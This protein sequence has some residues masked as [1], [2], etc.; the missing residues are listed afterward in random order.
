MVALLPI[1]IKNCNIPQKW[2]VV[3]GQT[4]REVLNDVHWRVFQPPT[5]KQ[6]PTTERG[7]YNVLCADG[8]FRRCK[9]VLAAWL[10]D[11]LGYRDLYS[12]EWHVCFRCECPKNKLGDYVPP[13]KQHPW[14]DD[15]LYQT[16]SDI[17]TMLPDAELSSCRDHRGFSVIRHIPCIVSDLPKPDLLHTMQISMLDHLQKWIFHYMKTHEWLDKYNAIWL[18]M[19]AYHD[20]TPQTKSYVEVSQWNAKEM[21]ELSQYLLGVVTQSLQ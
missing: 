10:P 20:L 2:L 1:P 7:Y 9:P 16:L 11:Y 17:D 14:R 13:N 12:R 3:Q 18:S 19:P 5:F 4:N 21:K 15:D 6:N 8:N